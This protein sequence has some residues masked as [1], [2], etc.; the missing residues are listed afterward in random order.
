MNNFS[1]Q[2][3]FQEGL[4]DLFDVIAYISKC[5]ITDKIEEDWLLLLAQREKGRR[6]K[7]CGV[8]RESTGSIRTTSSETENSSLKLCIKNMFNSTCS[9][10]LYNCLNVHHLMIKMYCVLCALHHD[11]ILLCCM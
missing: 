9:N 3:L 5:H 6:R 10:H 11:M 4:D 2:A 8:Y 1:N 7:M